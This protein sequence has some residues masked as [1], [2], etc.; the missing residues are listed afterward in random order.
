M[1]CSGRWGYNKEKGKNSEWKWRNNCSEGSTSMKKSIEKS[2]LIEPLNT[3]WDGALENILGR[4]FTSPNQCSFKAVPGT[5][6]NPGASEKHKTDSDLK[7]VSGQSLLVC[8]FMD[9]H[10]C[11]VGMYVCTCRYVCV[12]EVETKLQC[13]KNHSFIYSFI[14]YSL[15]TYYVQDTVLGLGVQQ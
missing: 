2:D 3:Q 5:V 4:R 15:R 11:Y 12:K 13:G 8:K 7:A 9:M 1:F 10:V 6:I 14:K